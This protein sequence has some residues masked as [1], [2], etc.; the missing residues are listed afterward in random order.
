VKYR[1]VIF[2]LYGTLVE[3]FPASQSGE[4]L[5]RMAEVLGVPPAAFS[6]Q[7]TK[8]FGD[9]MTGVHDNFQACTKSICLRLGAEPTAE[10]IDKA[11]AIRFELTHREVTSCMEGAVEVLSYLKKSGYKTGLVSNCSMETVKVWPQSLL[12]PFIDAPVFSCVEGVMK[13]DPRLFQI[14]MERLNVR[15]AECLYVA[16]GM[17]RELA[18]ASELG[19]QALL[20][21]VPHDSEYEHD[22]EEWHGASIASLQE[23]INQL[24]K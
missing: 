24:E 6:S 18:T 13:P 8:A 15:G 1:A 2:D 3:N 9:R 16:D 19:M 12:A 7:W 5:S 20:I 22:R 11:A 10:Q 17:S 14:V 23:I 4:V 21:K